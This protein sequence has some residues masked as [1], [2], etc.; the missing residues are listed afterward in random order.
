MNSRA[1]P[2][3][4]TFEEARITWDF[5]KQS[6]TCV[7]ADL[8]PRGARLRVVGASDLPQE[9]GLYIPRLGH[10]TRAR[11]VWRQPTSCGVEF[12][13]PLL[14]GHLVQRAS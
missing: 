1:E 12:V 8:S 5:R 11:I 13:R 10:W 2:R 4:S 3:A 6:R 7:L 14:A 9:F